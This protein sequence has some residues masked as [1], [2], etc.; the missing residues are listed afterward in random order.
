MKNLKWLLGIAVLLRLAGLTL[1]RINRPLSS[2][3]NPAYGATNSSVAAVAPDPPPFTPV[4]PLVL[5]TTDTNAAGQRMFADMPARDRRAIVEEIRK[6]DFDSIM[7]TWL[8]AGRVE[9]DP[10]KQSSI[11]SV[12]STAMR[13]KS[14]HWNFMKK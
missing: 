10:I 12:W 8:D 5:K 7:R 1:W 13:K 3:K 9:H 2:S 14:R 11:A 6:L 4:P